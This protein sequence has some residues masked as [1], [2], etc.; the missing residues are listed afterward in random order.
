MIGIILSAFGTLITLITLIVIIKFHNEDK[1]NKVVDSYVQFYNTSSDKNKFE[2]DAP[3]Y[4]KKA[5]A[6]GLSNK[7]IKKACDKIR[8]RNIPSPLKYAEKSGNLNNKNYKEML[9]VLNP[10][11]FK[12]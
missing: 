4:F 3:K 7:Q 2:I 9:E 12:N 8:Q 6:S 10:E 5:G 11:E 1:I